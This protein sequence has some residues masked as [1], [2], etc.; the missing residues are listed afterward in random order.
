MSRDGWLPPGVEHG[1]IDEWF[2]EED[3]GTEIDTEEG[4]VVLVYQ[5][6]DTVVFQIFNRSGQLETEFSLRGGNKKWLI[7]AVMDRL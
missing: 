3:P 1:D 5:D 2:G 6:G 7:D 4:G